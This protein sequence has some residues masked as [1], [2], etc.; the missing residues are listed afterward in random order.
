MEHTELFSRLN[1]LNELLRRER[2][3]ITHLQMDRLRDIQEQKTTL[4][5]AIHP[6]SH[7]LDDTC[8]EL[9]ETVQANNRRNGWLLRSGLKLVGRLQTFSR[10]K[11]PLTYTAQ[12]QSLQI[13]EGPKVYARRV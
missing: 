2:L 1:E 7:L 3:A 11:L 5:A 9:A 4:L 8:R 6:L 10:R 13:D 12:A